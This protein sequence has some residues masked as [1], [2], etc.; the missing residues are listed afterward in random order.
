MTNQRTNKLTM[1]AMLCAISYVVMLV[2]RIPISTVEFLKYDPK[3]AI[4]TIGGF[5]F[6]PLSA[7]LVTFIVAFV[8]MITV[9]STGYIGFI[10]N[11]IATCAFA[12]TATIIYKKK[13]TLVGAVI[14]LLAGTVAMTIVMMLWN[15]LLTPIF[16]NMDRSA[17]ANMLIPVFLPFNALKGGLNAGLT[18]FIYK[19]IVTALR[20]A[21]LI[22]ASTNQE[23]KKGNTLF[24]GI[25]SIII[26][27]A[28]VLLILV[29]KKII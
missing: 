28:C 7:F 15:Y 27:V 10:M 20:K 14:G 5:I 2:G 4:I 24:I 13:H 16:W 9:S 1:L 23:T 11:V 6:G 17:V 8:E 12:C 22:S 3:D 26:I 18:L 29:H 21:N 19:P 25:V